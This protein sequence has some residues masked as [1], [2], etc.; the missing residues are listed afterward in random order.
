MDCGCK[1]GWAQREYLLGELQAHKTTILP[2]PP[3][4]AFAGHAPLK[5]R[6]TRVRLLEHTGT[7]RLAKAGGGDVKRQKCMHS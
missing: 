5:G 2:P 6:T 3:A 1:V 4:P 7:I